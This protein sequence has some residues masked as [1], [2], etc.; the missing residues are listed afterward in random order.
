MVNIT[1]MQNSNHISVISDFGLKYEQMVLLT[2][3]LPLERNYTSLKI[4]NKNKQ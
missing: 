2:Q 4:I 1:L 3:S